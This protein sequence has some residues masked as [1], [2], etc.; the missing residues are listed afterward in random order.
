MGQCGK[1]RGKGGEWK[2][3]H[4]LFCQTK[5]NDEDL[6][7]PLGQPHHKVVWL[8]VSMQK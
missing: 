7:T 6:V 4:V 8:D 5:V 2:G 3:E 1:R